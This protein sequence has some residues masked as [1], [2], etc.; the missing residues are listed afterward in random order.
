MDLTMCAGYNLLMSASVCEHIQDCR[1]YKL[2][3]YLFYFSRLMDMD[4]R[5]ANC[6]QFALIPQ[7]SWFQFVN[8]F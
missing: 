4:E 3:R 2:P 5:K 1:I 8:P 6:Q 7:H